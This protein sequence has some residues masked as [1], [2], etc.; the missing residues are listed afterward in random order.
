MSV[1]ASPFLCQHRLACK[2]DVFDRLK[3]CCMFAIY[4]KVIEIYRGDVYSDGQIRK[5]AIASRSRASC[6]QKVITVQN[7]L[8][9]SLKVTEHGTIRKLGCNFLYGM[10]TV[11]RKKG[12]TDFFAVTFTNI[13]GFS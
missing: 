10:Y 7:D 5:L 11:S 3:Y 12:A 1:R 4:T 6:V 9:M 13:D 8:Q 2:I